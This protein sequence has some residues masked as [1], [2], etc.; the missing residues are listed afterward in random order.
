MLSILRSI[1]RMTIVSTALSSKQ[2]LILEE[3]CI[4]NG[5]IISL[6][7]RWHSTVI[8]YNIKKGLLMSI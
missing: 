3:G 5:C 6:L 7:W 2:Q 1:D 4:T 8:N